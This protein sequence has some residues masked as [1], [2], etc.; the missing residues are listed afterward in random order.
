[1]K[2]IHTT[3]PVYDSLDKQDYRRTRNKLPVHCPR[4]RLPAMQWNVEDD[5]PGELCSMRLVD[6]DGTETELLLYWFMNSIW[7]INTGWA[8]VT[9][10]G[11]DVFNSPNGYS[12]NATKTTAIDVDYAFS[13]VFSV[14]D[15][16]TYLLYTN[17]DLITGVAPQAYIVDSTGAIISNVVR[18]GTGISYPGAPTIFTYVMNITATDANARIRFRHLTTELSNYVL[19]FFIHKTTAPALYNDLTDSYFQY[20]GGIS[21]GSYTAASRKFLP[22]GN[23][24]LKMTTVKNYVYY[25]EIFAVTD[26]Y[27]NL[28]TKWENYSYDVGFVSTG[29][30]ITSAI[31]TA[32]SG[33][34]N[35]DGFSVIAGENIKVIFFLTLTSGT[36]PV[37]RLANDAYSIIYDTEAVVIGLNV[38]TLTATITGNVLIYFSNSA[39]NVDF[40][41]SEILVMREYSA[42]HIKINFDNTKDL[43]DIL[44]Q[45]G[46]SQTLWLPT[47]LAPPQSEQIDIGE[48]KNG[49]FIAEKIVNKFKFK[50]F[51]TMGRELYRAVVRIPLHDDIDIIDEVGNT[52]SPAVGNIWVNA[53]NWP[54]F[55]YVQVE[56]LF[57]DNNEIYFVSNNAN[58]T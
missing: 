39:T 43:G 40:S 1:M 58:F 16:E 5:D 11:Y 51:T 45:D 33:L 37:I 7:H 53:L 14:V 17:L 18:I 44:Y 47:Q 28:I 6:I 57:N 4:W 13:D 25:S 34:A 41:T 49:I 55:D 30:Q 21:G 19:T 22:Y 15:R 38:I 24:Y 3:L 12:F 20:K 2:T 46:F 32:G 9:N 10:A 27:P 26:I 8:A 56:I 48:E 31:N 23:Y 42:T 35:S 50:I 36:L 54:G 29:T 52:Y